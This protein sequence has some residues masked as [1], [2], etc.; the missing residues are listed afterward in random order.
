VVDPRG[1]GD[2]SRPPDGYDLDTV[3]ADLAA[4]ATEIAG[5]APL[6]VV[7][8][9][10]GTW[11]AHAWALHRPEQFRRLV[12]VDAA[13]PGVSPPVPGL[14]DP[15]ANLRTWHFA[16]NRLPGL[17]EL[18][19]TGREREFLAWLFAS[20]SHDPAVFTPEALDEYTRILAA[21]GAY[22][23]GL[24]YYRTAFTPAGLARAAQ[25]AGQPLRPP[26]LAVGG[27]SGVGAVLGDTLA[28]VSTEVT[29]V[30]IGDCG[31]YVP[32]EQPAALVQAITEFWRSHP[33]DQICG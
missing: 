20:K 26:V 16:F 33:G 7:A 29:T 17:P 25:R 21:P 14:P 9:D 3:A 10:V 6:D 30:V 28:S 23:A 5:T 1:L 27:A 15:A 22:A 31:H 11:I 32:E 19:V 24:Q 2:S 12:L 4:L 13:I 8:H 18:L